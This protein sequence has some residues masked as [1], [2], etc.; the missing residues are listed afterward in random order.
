MLLQIKWKSKC[1]GPCSE[2]Q[3]GCPQMER[4]CGNSD[5]KRWGAS[6]ATTEPARFIEANYTHNINNNF[7]LII[8]KPINIKHTLRKLTSNRRQQ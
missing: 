8:N 7:S 5:D 3:N 4:Q 6:V 1:C 2:K